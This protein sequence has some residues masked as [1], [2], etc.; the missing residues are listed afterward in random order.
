MQKGKNMGIMTTLK[1]T[2]P[3]KLSDTPPLRHSPSSAGRFTNDDDGGSDDDR[4]GDASTHDGGGN[5]T[6]NNGN[7]SS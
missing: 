5:E 1:K 4:D 7:R 2:Y 3:R 6:Q